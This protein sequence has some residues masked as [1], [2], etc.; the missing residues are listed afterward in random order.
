MKRTILFTVLLFFVYELQ[1]QDRYFGRTYTANVLAKG[2]VDLELWHTSRFGHSNEFFHAMDQ[3]MELEIGLGKG[4]QPAFY[5]NHFQ[6]SYSDA[7][8][9]IV[10][11]TEAG[12]SNEWKWQINKPAKKTNI[13]LYGELGVKGNEIELET[14]LILDRTFGK[15]LVAFNLVYEMEYEFEKQ[16]NKTKLELAQ[17]PVEFDLAF[18]HFLKPELGLG[19]ETVS[20]NDIVKGKVNNSILYAGPTLTYRGGAWFVIANYLPQ[21]VNLHKTSASPFKRDLENH[22]RAEARILLGISL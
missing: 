4:L 14:K 18:M 6:Q 5:F 9:N 3:R 10:H 21:L 17:T 22:E 8:G 11:K 7:S 19:L 15:N 2:G 1:A 20:H 16:N 12:F 13:A